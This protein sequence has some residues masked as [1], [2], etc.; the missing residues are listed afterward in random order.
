MSDHVLPGQ[1]KPKLIVVI[2]FDRGNEGDLF[3]AY[4]PADQQSEERAVRIAK[5]LAT[6]M[7]ASSHGA[8]MP[9]QRLG[10]TARLQRFSSAV[11]YPTWNDRQDRPRV[12]RFAGAPF[13]L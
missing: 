1:K 10:T 8:A 4:G 7:S 5:A 6:S 11:T 12:T 3:A 9:I 13:P 2:A